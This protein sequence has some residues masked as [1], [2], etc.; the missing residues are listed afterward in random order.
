MK[1]VH[2]LGGG[3]F[4]HVRSHMAL[5]AP[6]FGGTARKLTELLRD[7]VPGVK[8]HLTKMAD[9]TSNIVTNEDVER[10]VDGLIAD[11]D[12][13]G[14]IF[15]VALCDFTGTIDEVQ[16]GKYATRLQSRGQAPSIQLS[17]AQKII[18]KIRKDRKDIF[19][20]GF[21]TT[22]GAEHKDQ[23]E[24]GLNLLKTNSI[25][26]VVANDVVTRRNMIIVP[27]EAWYG[28]LSDR[29]YSLE[30]LADMFTA[31][32]NLTYTRS[33]VVPGES[34]GWNSPQVPWVLKKVVDHCISRGAYKPFNGKTAGH[35]AFKIDDNIFATS[36]RKT[37]YNFLDKDGLV[38]VVARDHDN[39]IAYGAKPSVG[40]QS[41][42]IVFS[43]HPEMDCIVHFHCPVRVGRPIPVRTQWQYECGSHECG[44]NTSDGLDWAKGY[45]LK[46]VYLDNHGPNIVFNSRTADPKLIIDYIEKNF[47]LEQKTG[48]LFNES[49]KTHWLPSMVS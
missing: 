47:D 48:G 35:F 31:R 34:I 7:R 32:Y 24:A 11:Q 42:R 44:K 16:S 14:I 19:T 10:L 22:A 37:N 23:Y 21:K 18:G 30:K 3:T 45:G 41:Q 33:E 46:A 26:L 2:V 38:K 6:A 17:P 1:F 39:V 5:A 13:K 12:T 8:L 27:E 25:N 40:G 20:V 49:Q 15:N 28:G 9:H 36:K 29:D 43:E 4:N